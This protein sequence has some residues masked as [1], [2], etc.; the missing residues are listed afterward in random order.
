MLTN[1]PKTKTNSKR[2]GRGKG[3]GKGKTSGRG[4]NGQR[5]RTG[6]S[7]RF[8]SGGQTKYYLALPKRGGFIN[9][10]KKKVIAITFDKILEKFKEDEIVSEE[11]VVKRFAIDERFDFVKII[12]KGK[13]TEKRNFD[14]KIVLSK[15]IK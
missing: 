4:M 2:L 5:S 9:P 8:I 10:R 14:Q 13:L 12:A 3:S 7:T 6:A 1:L 11:E 15:S